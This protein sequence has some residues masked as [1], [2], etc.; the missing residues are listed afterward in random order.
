MKNQLSKFIFFL[1]KS[2]FKK[3]RN[4]Y[5]RSFKDTNLRNSKFLVRLTFEGQNMRFV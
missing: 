3:N 4:E 5:F 1:K 2:I